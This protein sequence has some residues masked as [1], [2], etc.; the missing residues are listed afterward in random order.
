MTHTKKN[1]QK[2]D[3]LKKTLQ[4]LLFVG[5]GVFFVWISV[6]GL[7]EENWI[8]IK[9]SIAGVNTAWGWTFLGFSFI[10]CIVAHYL[11][12]TRSILL[13]ESMNYSVRKSMSFY[14]VMVCYLANIVFPRLGEVLRCTF[15]QRY[16]KVPFQKALG[17]IVSERALDMIIWLFLLVIAIL[18]NTSVLME[19]TLTDDGTTLKQFIE[20]KTTGLLTN[21]LFYLFIGLF[22]ITI[23]VIY[24]T[25][26][27][28][29]KIAFFNKIKKFVMGIWQGLIS[30]KDLKRPL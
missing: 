13:M 27:R 15:L 21:Y 29:N 14:A 20:A 22:I 4:V 5:L 1:T 3:W 24:M 16:E 7:S 25:R 11:R 9:E 17:T 23:V 2:Y 26:N 28:W 8:H 12:G 19:L 10:C 18:L 30:I 6:R